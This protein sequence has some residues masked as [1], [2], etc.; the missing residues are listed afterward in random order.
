V[1][2]FFGATMSIGCKKNRQSPSDICII[3]QKPEPTPENP[4]IIDLCNSVARLE[5]WCAKKALASA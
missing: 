2:E 1:H 5:T 3:T 4:E